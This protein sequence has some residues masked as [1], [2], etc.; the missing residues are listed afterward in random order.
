[1]T[2][3][4]RLCSCTYAFT[5]KAHICSGNADDPGSGVRKPGFLP[6]KTRIVC[7]SNMVIFNLLFKI[8]I[9][10]AFFIALSRWTMLPCI[11]GCSR[12]Y[13]PYRRYR[14]Q[15]NV[16]FFQCCH[17]STKLSSSLTRSNAGETILLFSLP[18]S[19]CPSMMSN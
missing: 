1:V 10:Y 13:P 8:E 14:R 19:T 9:V 18:R 6:L 12:V 15:S 11:S 2:L 3:E 17:H 7:V 4:D 16:P 5:F